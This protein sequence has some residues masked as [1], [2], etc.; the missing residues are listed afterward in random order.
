MAP[1][2]WE[3]KNK[4]SVKSEDFGS[5]GFAFESFKSNTWKFLIQ[6]HAKDMLSLH[7]CSKEGNAL[8]QLH[9][10]KAQTA[11]TFIPKEFRLVEAF[12]YTL[13]GFFL[14][15]YDDSPAGIFDEVGMLSAH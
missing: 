6:R 15:H 4:L 11:R 13:G 10:V 2:H 5:W 8:Y 1:N 3:M 9:L 7:G 14:A 12:G